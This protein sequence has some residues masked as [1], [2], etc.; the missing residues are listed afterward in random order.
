MRHH[1]IAILTAAFIACSKSPNPTAHSTV[2]GTTPNGWLVYEDDMFKTAY[3]PQ[4]LLEGANEGKQNP[5]N[6]YL[7]IIP[8]PHNQGGV[9]GFHLMPDSVTKNMLLRDA[10]Q[11]DIMRFKGTTGSLIAGPKDV[12]VKNGRCISALVVTPADNCPKNAGSCYSP[13]YLTQCDGPDGTRYNAHTGLS[14]GQS[15]SAL[16]PQAQQEAATYER[17]LRSLEFKKS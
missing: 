1:F 2:T 17:I 14:V 8:P 9:G 15:R 11:S 6:V 5:K 12:P 4:S 7:S 13:L 16:A 10:L 3:P